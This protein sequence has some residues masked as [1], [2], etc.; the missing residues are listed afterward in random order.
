MKHS[1]IGNG[2]ATVPQSEAASFEGGEQTLSTTN[3]PPPLTLTSSLIQRAQQKPRS[4]T[5]QQVLQ[6]QHTIG[7]RAVYRLLSPNAQSALPK[8]SSQIQR[9]Y[10]VKSDPDRVLEDTAA[11]YPF[12]NLNWKAELDKIYTYIGEVK[13]VLED[14]DDVNFL[15]EWEDKID[16][17][18]KEVDELTLEFAKAPAYSESRPRRSSTLK[19][20]MSESLGTTVGK[21]KRPISIE[22]ASSVDESSSKKVRVQSKEAI[23][24]EINEKTIELSK[25]FQQLKSTF[26]LNEGG[27]SA[28]ARAHDMDE[29]MV[30]TEDHEAVKTWFRNIKLD[31][32]FLSKLKK[33]YKQSQKKVE[34]AGKP[35]ALSKAA[36]DTTDKADKLKEVEKLLTPLQLRHTPPHFKRP[37]LAID[38]GAGQLSA[39][40][41]TNASGYAMLSGVPEWESSRWEWLHIRAASLGGVTDSSNLVVGTRDA[42]T[43]MMPFE[44]NIRLLA[45]IVSENDNY[46]GLKVEFKAADQDSIAKHKVEEISI[47]WK[48]LKADGAAATVK[49]AEGQAKFNPLNTEA[50]IS[51]TEVAILEQTLKE[52]REELGK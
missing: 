13:K 27:F 39:M 1:K 48:L 5:A 18:A 35:T 6:L 38:R 33:V 4:L 26:V 25:Q 7:N 40:A 43:H 17:L 16:V 9:L 46:K 37:P 8:A 23:S 21:R 49:E 51:K 50:S 20:P 52:K 28:K 11:S 29:K 19:S 34:D 47:S 15:K 22:I 3:H 41:G 45:K 10:T 31:K 44:A 2:F 14:D 30:A 36:A 32:K 42:N 12:R 24:W